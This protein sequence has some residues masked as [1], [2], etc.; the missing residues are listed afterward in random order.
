MTRLS[1][2]RALAWLGGSCRVQFRG[3][4]C[5]YRILDRIDYDLAISAS[6]VPTGFFVEIFDGAYETVMGG[7]TDSF[8]RGVRHD[9]R[10]AKVSYRG[11]SKNLLAGVPPPVVKPLLKYIVIVVRNVVLYSRPA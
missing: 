9:V 10:T 8:K 11:L 7:V 1:T 2:K 3:W 4:D 6:K 5:R